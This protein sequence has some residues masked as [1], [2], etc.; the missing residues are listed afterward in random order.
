MWKNGS[1]WIDPL[2]NALDE[3][4][5]QMPKAFDEHPHETFRRSVWVSPPFWR[6][7]S[8]TSS[9]PSA[10]TRCCSAPTGHIPKL[11]EPKGFYKYAEGMDLRR[12][13]DY[14]GDNAR[15]FMGGLPIR[16]PD[17]DAV[18]APVLETASI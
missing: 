14:M 9:R 8:P 6:A 5:H 2:F 15:R 1:A 11:A 4:Y 16:N 3:V 12:S 7:K 10:G 13:Y 17:P 18:N